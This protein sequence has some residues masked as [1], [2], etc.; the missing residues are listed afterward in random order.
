MITDSDILKLKKIYKPI[1]DRV[2]K[3]RS[4]HT[5]FPPEEEVLSALNID[6]NTVKCVILGQDPYIQEQQAHGLSF[7][8]RHGIKVPPS[9][10][11]IFK[12]LK[13]DLNIEPPTHGNLENWKNEGVLLLNRMLT[14][15]AGKPLSH[16][17]IGWEEF[18]EEIIKLINDKLE[19][20]VFILWG[21][22]A[23]Q[24]KS[25]IDSKK[26]LI[27]TSVHPSPLSANKGFF[28]CRHFSKTNRYLEQHG[29][30]PINWKLD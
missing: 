30:V 16:A 18:T 27:L 8:V 12:E 10:L 25:L 13:T 21:K 22:P 6:L 24:V 20:V 9:L 28:G 15:E 2:T 4:T 26:H 5:I 23:Q 7:S 3:L 19:N 1:K 14:V 29:K 11:N 17:N